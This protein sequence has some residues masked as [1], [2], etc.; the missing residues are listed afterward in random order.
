MSEEDYGSIIDDV[1][2]AIEWK[3]ILGLLGKLKVAHTV[4]EKIDAIRPIVE[5]V[6]VH[7]FRHD[8]K[9]D[10]WY[11]IMRKAM[12]TIKADPQWQA[13]LQGLFR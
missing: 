8:P 10:R 9:N 5:F 3:P 13:V 2:L 6:A 1:S 11:L 7:A 4:P 12:E